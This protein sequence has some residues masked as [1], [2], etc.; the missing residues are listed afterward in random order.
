MAAANTNVTT[1]PVVP[2]AVP[3]PSGSPHGYLFNA[4]MQTAYLGGSG[5]SSATGFP[6]PPNNRVDLSTLPGTIYGVAGFAPV[7]PAGTTSSATVYPA[8]T[9][10][11]TSAAIT[12][13]SLI[14]IEAGTGRQEVQT[15][16]GTAGGTVFTNAAWTFAHASGVAITTVNPLV[17]TLKVTPGAT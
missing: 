12:P 2:V 17:T 14:V 11:T 7:A 10:V 8:G 15:V 1:T 16:G 3:S 9:A 13:G 5:V 4:G 6:L